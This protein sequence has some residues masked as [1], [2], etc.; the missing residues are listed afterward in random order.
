MSEQVYKKALEGAYNELANES[1]EKNKAWSEAVMDN[2]LS[3][4]KGEIDL[5]FRSGTPR[6]EI[7]GHYM[8][9]MEGDISQILYQ[10]LS[11]SSEFIDKLYK[12]TYH[13]LKAL[14]QEGKSYGDLFMEIDS[15]NTYL[16]ELFVQL[17]EELEGVAITSAKQLQ[18]LTGIT[19]LYSYFDSDRGEDVYYTGDSEPTKEEAQA[20]AFK[21]IEQAFTIAM[22]YRYS[23]ALENIL[24]AGGKYSELLK[25][26]PSY[27]NLPDTWE[28]CL[29]TDQYSSILW[30]IEQTFKVSKPI[31]SVKPDLK[32]V[33]KEIEA[34]YSV[35]MDVYR[36]YSEWKQTPS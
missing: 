25:V 12:D 23:K 5:L 6:D 9:N 4:L 26:K 35:L 8:E 19:E 28:G 29:P 33:A 13:R 34:P 24:Q 22:S 30:A 3:D 20:I 18:E 31:N 36:V 16:N 32:A 11:T 27:F 21:E 17:V 10:A 2:Y 1:P 15:D 7:R 14:A